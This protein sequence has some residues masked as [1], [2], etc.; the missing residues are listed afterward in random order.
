[1]REIIL[2]DPKL[3]V[4]ERKDNMKSRKR[5]RDDK[6]PA[7]PKTPLTSYAI[8]CEEKRFRL[9]Q[10]N[11]NMDSKELMT[12]LGKEWQKPSDQKELK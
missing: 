10:K 12:K 6:D 2:E 7:F 4:A 11:T 8:F 3:K 5:K 9:A 1:M